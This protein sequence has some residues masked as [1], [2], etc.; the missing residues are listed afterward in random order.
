[1]YYCVQ[2]V[3]SFIYL[4]I[5]LVVTK[6]NFGS[7]I[8]Q[9]FLRHLLQEAAVEF[10]EGT[11]REEHLER[12]RRVLQTHGW[13]TW[14]ASIIIRNQAAG[15][16]ACLSRYYPLKPLFFMQKAK[17]ASWRRCCRMRSQWWLR[18]SPSV[19]MLPR[20]RPPCGAA[21]VPALDVRETR[22]RSGRR[23]P[24]VLGTVGT[25][26][27]ERRGTAGK[28]VSSG[29]KYH[30]LPSC[31]QCSPLVVR[32]GI[33]LKQAT[34]DNFKARRSQFKKASKHLFYC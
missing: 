15:A 26:A 3:F 22:R 25:G 32:F 2:H 30:T 21:S 8:P 16:L 28:L 27:S 10:G 18:A 12:H 20:R 33:A 6:T 11:D 9:N 7:F 4:F 24:Q 31:V 14:P 1:M 13:V 23:E 34:N 5:F 17:F 19:R 29:P